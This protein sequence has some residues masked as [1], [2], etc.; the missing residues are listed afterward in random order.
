LCVP[1]WVAWLRLFLIH[2]LLIWWVW[3]AR[4]INNLGAKP[5]RNE[6]D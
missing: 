2:P 1:M 6:F 3:Q 4:N 5:H